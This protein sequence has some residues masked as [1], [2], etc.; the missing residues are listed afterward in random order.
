MQ[1]IC[2]HCRQVVDALVTKRVMPPGCQ[3]DDRC[4]RDGV[5]ITP[6]CNSFKG[7]PNE[8]C[9]ACEHPIECHAF[10]PE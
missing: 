7:D 10:K 8:N 2:P 4:W 1:M 5:P 3:C 9:D 6:I